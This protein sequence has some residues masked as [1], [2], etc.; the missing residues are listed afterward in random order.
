MKTAEINTVCTM[1]TYL[2]LLP[3]FQL[4]LFHYHWYK[5]SADIYN[6]SQNSYCS[7]LNYLD[8]IIESFSG[9]KESTKSAWVALVECWV[10][11]MCFYFHIIVKWFNILSI[12]AS[13]IVSF[14]LYMFQGD[15]G[16][17]VPGCWNKVRLSQHCVFAWHANFMGNIVWPNN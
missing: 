1:S 12:V 6:S 16:L 17:P 8:V 10:V 4:Y 5:L 14:L 2:R 9:L 3:L 13:N 11:K 7:G 15:D